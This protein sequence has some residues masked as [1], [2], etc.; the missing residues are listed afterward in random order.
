MKSKLIIV[1]LLIFSHT[2]SSQTVRDILNN[3]YKQYSANM[4]LNFET[5]YKL[6]K[7]FEASKVHQNYTGVFFKNVENNMYIKIKDT[8]ILN[9]KD[10][11]LKISHQEKALIVSKPELNVAGDYDMSALLEVYKDN[12]LQDKGAYWEIELLPNQIG[13]PYSKI[14]LHIAKDYFI[15]KQIFFYGEGVNFSN[16][17]K[18]TDIQFPRLEVLYTHYNRNLADENKFKTSSFLTIKV[19]GS[20]K[21]SSSLKDYE[22]I[23]KRSDL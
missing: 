21:L 15:K 16:D 1:L 2:A 7:T 19:D 12:G 4:P 23:D 8:E 22:L 3:V 5:N 11:N 10:V 17:Y 14:V 6:Y 20:I 18:K 13:L 9:N